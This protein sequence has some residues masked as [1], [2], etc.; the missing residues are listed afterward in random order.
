MDAKVYIVELVDEL[1]DIGEYYTPGFVFLDRNAA[2][3]MV[4]EWTEGSD[5]QMR[6]WGYVREWE[7]VE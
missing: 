4:D 7:V 6:R 3:E 2:Q 5:E 1:M